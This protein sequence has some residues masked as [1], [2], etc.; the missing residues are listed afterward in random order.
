MAELLKNQFFHPVF[1]EKLRAVLA[2]IHPE[3]PGKKFYRLVYDKEWKNEELKQRMAHI[4]RALHQTLPS[5]YGQA[6][7]ILMKAAPHFNGFDG[8]VF[9]DYVGQF[10]LDHWER[11]ME[12][13]ELFTQYSSSEFAIRPLII[14][15]EKMTLKRMEEWSRDPNHHLRRLASEGCRPR[16][17]WAMALPKFKQD[18]LPLRSILENLKSDTSDYV[19]KSVANNLNDISKDNKE[20]VLKWITNWN[21]NPSPATHWIIK[22]AL[23]GLVKAG[24]TQALDLLGYGK[25]NVVLHNFKVTPT[26]ISMGESITLSFELQNHDGTPHSLMVDYIIH[27]AKAN[28]KNAPKVFKLTSLD[29]PPKNRK[30][31]SKKHSIQPITTRKYYSGKHLLEIQ[32][33]GKMLG[34]SSFELIV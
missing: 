28:G 21:Q 33:N 30:L 25:A 2:G 26:K 1:L 14:R 5:D 27:F 9:P 19:R 10:G 17:P 20:L 4:S 34:K 29:L 31:L 3:F 8:M 15:Y 11:S 12:A 24:D 32:V 22:H 18:P 6:I 7:E 13:L 16:L 23:R